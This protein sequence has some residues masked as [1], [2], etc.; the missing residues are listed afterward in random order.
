MRVVFAGT[1]AVALPSLEALAGSS[2]EVVGVVTRPDAARGRSGRLVASDVGVRAAELGMTVLKP[3]HPRDP[4]FM[5]QLRGLAP[6]ACAVVA[7]GA[8]EELLRTHAGY[9]GVVARALDAETGEAD[10]D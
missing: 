6:D 9:R 7:Y 1:P 4:Q 3:G 10:D 2:H 5:E 8:H